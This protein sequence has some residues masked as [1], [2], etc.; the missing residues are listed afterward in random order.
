MTVGSDQQHGVRAGARVGLGDQDLGRDRQ[1]GGDLGQPGHQPGAQPAFRG[2]DGGAGRDQQQQEARTEPG[3]QPVGGAVGGQHRQVGDEYP[4]GGGGQQFAERG[5]AA[6]AALD[7]DPP[8]HAGG[9]GRIGGGAAEPPGAE[10]P[11]GE[12]RRV[13]AEGPGEQRAP[14]LGPAAQ[15]AQQR[16]GLVDGAQ[17]GADRAAA[18]GLVAVEQGATG[19]GAARVE[20]PGE[21]EPPGQVVGVAQAVGEV[22]HAERA[23]QMGGVAGQEAAADPEPGG[24]PL[25][26]GVVGGG[27]QVELREFAAPAGEGGGDPG[28]QGVAGD[29]AGPGGVRVDRFGGG[30]P[31]RGEPPV[32]PPDAVRQRAG[33][34]LAVAAPRGL[35]VQPGFGERQ[36]D[37]DGGDRAAVDGGPPGEADLQ[38]FADGR[39]GAVAADQVAAAPPGLGAVLRVAGEHVDAVAVLFEPG[40]PAQ[41]NEF[42]QRAAGEGVAQAAL[43]AVLGQ[44]QHGGVGQVDPEH[45]LAAAPD[46]EGV[47][48]GGVGGGPGVAD[49][50]QEG[51]GVG[52]E[53]DAAGALGA[54]SGALVE[55]DGRDLVPG[56]GEGQGQADRPGPDHD[57]RVHAGPSGPG[58][59]PWISEHGPAV[60]LPSYAAWMLP[61]GV[62]K[63]NATVH[64][65][66]RQAAAEVR[67]FAPRRPRASIH[68]AS[69]V[70]RRHIAM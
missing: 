5:G 24:Q 66:V 50:G 7:R 59:A 54:E 39:T 29:D 51:G 4:G 2:P 67:R 62:T 36:V 33:G 16:H 37:P 35:A 13:L 64:L 12:H 38:Q 32:E 43:E 40:D 1:R 68:R 31:A 63:S 55:D 17:P 30:G 28:E 8:G 42:D 23:V 20:V 22:L 69:A 26:G 46:G 53:D 21:G 25:L 34:G 58:R 60:S 19:L 27:E 49:P 57:H 65:R 61:D 47:P 15:R 9:R 44:V 52:T 10:V 48:A 56:Q 45:L 6:G 14:G 3:V 11:V 18:F 41:R 70:S